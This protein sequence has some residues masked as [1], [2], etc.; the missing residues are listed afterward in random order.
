MKRNVRYVRKRTFKKFKSEE[1]IEAVKQISWWELYCSQDPEE[2]ATLLTNKLT[3]ILDTMAPLK[4]IQVRNK[5]APWLSQDTKQ[6]MKERNKAQETAAK[7]RDID[8]W[9]LYKSLRNR[10]TMRMRQERKLWEQLK[11][12]STKH[13]PSSLWKNVKMWLNWNNSGPPSQLFHQ[14]MLINS[15]A[16]LAGTMNSFFTNKVRTLREGIPATE[17]DPLQVLRNS[18]QNRECSFQFRAVGPDEVLKVLTGLKNS[19]A[20]GTDNIETAVVK[21]IAQDILAPLTHIINLSIENSSFPKL[22][23][24]AKVIP[25]LKKGDPLTPKNYRPT[26]YLSSPMEAS[27]PQLMKNLSLF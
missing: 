8:D 21:L 16:G 4:T 1:F 22:W 14:G 13:S 5:Y 6:L 7:T 26:P 12:D 18:F 20:T 15:P 2:A 24:Q 10:T 25:L 11:L 19:K 3:I 27:S 23:K 17:A 9:R